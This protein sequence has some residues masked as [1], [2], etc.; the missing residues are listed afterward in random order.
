MDGCTDEDKHIPGVLWN[1]LMITPSYSKTSVKHF[2]HDPQEVNVAICDF[3]VSLF[4]YMLASINQT[5]YLL[6][7][8]KVDFW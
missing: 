3:I 5:R 7:K 6:N 8:Y 2:N 4:K 1:I